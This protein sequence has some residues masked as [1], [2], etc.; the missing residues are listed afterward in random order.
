M[1]DRTAR[2]LIGALGA[3]CLVLVASVVY[4]VTLAE[5]HASR[6]A[7]DR[8]EVGDAPAYRASGSIVVDGETVLRFAE[9]VTADGQRYG[10]VE[11]GDVRSERY[12]STP[13]GTVLSRLELP[14]SD[15]DRRRAEFAAS[16]DVEL[17]R[18]VRSGDRVAF[19]LERPP[20]ALPDGVSGA[21]S[22]VVRSL[23]VPAYGLREE[24]DGG[25]AVYEPRDGWYD[26]SDPYRI[27]GASGTVRVDA[28]TNAVRSARVAWDATS[29]AGTYAEYVLARVTGDDPTTY[30]LSFEFD[31]GDATVDRPTWVEERGSDG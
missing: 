30:E 24:E 6:P 14:R 5:P 28:D 31:A 13:N 18:E 25:V 12:Q 7:A 27:T 3:C 23:Y 4:P 1:D 16:D 10:F 9:V 21:A 17:V 15:A 2:W 26:G 8:F 22:V 29:A 11:D 20:T 19:V